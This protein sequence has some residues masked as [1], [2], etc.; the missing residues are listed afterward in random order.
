M[1]TREVPHHRTAPIMTD[2]HRF[3]TPRRIEQFDHVAHDEFLRV[4]AVL[5]VNRRSSIAA[6]VGRDRAKSQRRK[7]GKLMAP[8]DRKLRPSVD[9]NYQRT[10][11]G[12]RCE[13]ETGMPGGF[14]GVFGD[15]HLRHLI[16]IFPR[17]TL[18]S[19]F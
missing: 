19:G 11:F 4:V 2:P 10:I 5:M 16:K 6:H 8:A 7:R 18:R 1:M 15:K 9:E 14:Y 17:T 3:L 13:V 12:T